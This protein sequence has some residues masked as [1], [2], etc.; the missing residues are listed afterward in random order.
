MFALFA[1]GFVILMAALACATLPRRVVR[2]I[3][4]YHIRRSYPTVT[5]VT[6]VTKYLQASPEAALQMLQWRKK[7][8]TNCNKCNKLLQRCRLRQYPEVMCHSRSYARASLQRIE[9][10]VPLEIRGTGRSPPTYAT[11]KN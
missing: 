1:L 2:Y 6:S 7:A 3:Q 10:A 4:I 5:S 11:I 8:V 9:L